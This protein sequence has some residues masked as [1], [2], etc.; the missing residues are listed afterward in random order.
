MDYIFDNYIGN[1]CKCNE[2]KFFC[3]KINLINKCKYRHIIYNYC[4]YFKIYID[5]NK[6]FDLINHIECNNEPYFA[7]ILEYLLEMLCINNKRKDY[8]FH[9]FIIIL[10]IFHLVF[11][12]KSKINEYMIYY[13]NIMLH[14]KYILLRELIYKSNKLK[15]IFSKYFNNT[16]S[17]NMNIIHNWIIL[18]DTIT[19]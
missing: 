15:G 8:N 11:S 7:R 13:E 9:K 3:Y 16:I 19:H 12:N 2:D 1:E 5:Y 17:H 14:L 10:N 6:K 18:L 4:P